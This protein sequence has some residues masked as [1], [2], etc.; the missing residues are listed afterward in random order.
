[1]AVRRNAPEKKVCSLRKLL[2]EFL[3]SEIDAP[4]RSINRSR[5]LSAYQESKIRC[6]YI[7][8]RSRL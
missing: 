7:S 4:H 6:F 3:N 1:L 8:I 2:N 5:D